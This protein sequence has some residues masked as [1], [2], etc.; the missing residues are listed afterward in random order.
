LSKRD[1]LRN[2]PKGRTQHELETLISHFGF[3]LDHITGSH[4]VFILE[5]SENTY[6]IV[7]P[8]HKGKVKPFYVKQIAELIDRAFPEESADEENEDD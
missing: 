2:N 5:E 7:V 8:I 4:H 1:K 3:V 6:R